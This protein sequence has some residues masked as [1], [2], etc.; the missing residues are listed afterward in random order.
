MKVKKT[1]LKVKWFIIAQVAL[2]LIA[3]AA[4]AIIPACNKYLVDYV[5]P[6]SGANLFPLVL[7]Y[8]FSFTVF[9][10]ATWGSERFVWKSAIAFENAL[11]K[12]CYAAISNIKFRD[13]SKK[14]SDEYLSL[15]TNNITSI[16]QDYLQPVCA[17]I[18]SII[19][20]IVYSVII[21]IYTSPIICATLLILSVIAACTPKLYQKK[22]S[23][24]GKEYVDGAAIYTKKTADL[25]DGAELI[26]KKSKEFFRKENAKNT[27]ILS[28]KRHS[29]GKAKVNGNIISGAAICMI[30]TVVFVLCG[31]LMLKGKITAGVIVAAITYAQSFTEP[32]EE[33]LYDINMLNSSK[34]IVDSL[35]GMLCANDNDEINGNVFDSLKENRINIHDV[36][37]KYTDK[38]IHYNVEFELGKKYIITG[39]SGH[40]K[41]TL[42]DAIMGRND[43]EGTVNVLSE[44]DCFYLSQH[45]HVFDDNAINNITLFG[46]YTQI[47]EKTSSN[48]PMFERI[49]TEQDCSV[50]SGGE[51]QILKFCR[52]LTQNKPILLLDE[53]FSALDNSNAARIFHFLST[54]PETVILVS[55]SIE[56]DGNDLSKWEVKKIEDICY[57]E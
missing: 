6:N 39:E 18:K 3:T 20:V 47:D 7:A 9:L 16:E 15:I 35:E 52:I 57:E 54:M 11:K 8:I 48:I 38:K 14:K 55:H 28:R 25:L 36:C 17:L 19:S 26:D 12:D 40:G 30:D 42:L 23:K 13:Y 4:M 2:S 34:E 49:I 33:I 32:V 45:Q 1:I 46:A 44:E 51:K 5:Y 22:L 24:S 31:I 43:V 56:F 10:V 50:L 27:D 37:V 29:L 53:P 41:T 21:S